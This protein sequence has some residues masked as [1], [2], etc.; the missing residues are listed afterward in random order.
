MEIIEQ[1]KSQVV[2]EGKKVEIVCKAIGFPPPQFLW[3]KDG[4]EFRHGCDNKLVFNSVQ[5]KDS[6]K[7]TC[8]VTNPLGTEKSKVA[9]LQVHGTPKCK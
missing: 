7:Y 1:P 3:L 2:Q 4:A 5:V 6:G 9:E 8:I